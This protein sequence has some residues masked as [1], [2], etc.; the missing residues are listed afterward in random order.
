MLSSLDNKLLLL[1][2]KHNTNIYYCQK[3]SKIMFIAQWYNM[4]LME[5]IKML[6]AQQL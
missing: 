4:L 1:E 6:L 3:T 5:F 2:D